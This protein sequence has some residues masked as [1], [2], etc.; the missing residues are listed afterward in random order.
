VKVAALASGLALALAVAGPASAQAP[1]PSTCVCK[2]SD[3]DAFTTHYLALD[4]H[5][6][7]FA[8]LRMRLAE[9]DYRP[10]G[11]VIAVP[12]LCPIRAVCTDQDKLPVDDADLRLKVLGYVADEGLVVDD[13]VQ[14][15]K[16]RRGAFLV[17]S[18]RVE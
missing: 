13:R 17:L 9:I 4:T 3:P 1:W 7:D 2:S 5:G 14:P 16:F 6:R 12:S 11:Q 8:R 10:I 18:G 15:D